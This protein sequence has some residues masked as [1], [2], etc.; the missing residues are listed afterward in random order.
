MP[1]AEL[2]YAGVLPRDE[3]AQVLRDLAPGTG[4]ADDAAAIA[5]RLGRLPLALTLAGGFLAHQVITPWTME[6]Y[7]RRLQERPDPI[8]LIDQSVTD[9]S[10]DSRHLVSGTWQLALNSLVGQNLPEAAT[11]LRL[12]VERP[13]APVAAGRRPA[14]PA[15]ACR[16]D[17][18][19]SGTARSLVSRGNYATVQT[20][21][22]SVQETCR[23]EVSQEARDDAWPGRI[24]HGRVRQAGLKAPLRVEPDGHAVGHH[25]VPQP[26]DEFR[27]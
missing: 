27:R 14:R 23:F 20:G 26:L 17:G 3:A 19:G 4:S 1:A 24:G 16:P 6:E 25:G 22:M 5:D 12:L 13:A 2:L 7:G 15:A 11:P 8:E 21:P 18:R 10:N 9:A